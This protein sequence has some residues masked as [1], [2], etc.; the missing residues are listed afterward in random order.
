MAQYSSS[1][2]KAVR[3]FERAQE[4]LHRADLAGAEEGLRA[5]LDA[6]GRFYEAHLSLADMLFDQ[7][8]YEEA[9]EH[10][11]RYLSLDQDHYRWR[12]AAE[13]NMKSAQFRFNAMEHPVPFDP[14]NLGPAVNSRDDEYLPAMTADGRTL[15]FTRRVPRR[16]TTTAATPEEEDFYVSIRAQASPDSPWKQARRLSEPVNS[17]DNEGAQCISYDGRVMLFTACGRPDGA[18]RCD[19]Y[20]S[21]WHGRQWGKPQNLGPAINSGNWEAQPTLSLNGRHMIFVSDRRGGCG[22]MDL[23]ESELKEGVWSTPKNLGPKINTSGHESGPFLYY[24]DSTL[25]FVSTGHIGM[26][27]SDLFVSKRQRDGS[28]GEPSNLGYPIN[29]EADESRLVVAADGHTCLFASDKLGGYGKQDIYFFDLPV[30]LRPP[31]VETHVE[32]ASA[33]TLKVGQSVTLKNLFFQTGKYALYETSLVE[34]DKVVELLEA[35]PG[36]KIELEGHTDNVGSAE[37]NQIL[38]EQRAKAAY[39]Y[40]VSRGIAPERLSYR[41]YGEE[42]PVADNDTEEGRAQNRRTVFVVVE[43]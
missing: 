36:M 39:D 2:R 43:K 33:D 1:S 25:F 4:C 13:H 18:G 34:L 35:N 32:I 41:G 15:I 20:Q 10:Y 37:S 14:V 16:R 21:V 28:W 23:W 38:S 11:D 5:A 8:R 12:D 24:D 30:S 42:R 40:I 26:G 17:T 29:T 31:E 27:G 9:V 6:D 3:A 22:G 19:L 7:R